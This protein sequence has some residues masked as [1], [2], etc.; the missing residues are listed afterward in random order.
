M[1]DE[2]LLEKTLAETFSISEEMSEEERQHQMDLRAAFK[3]GVQWGYDHPYFNKGCPNREWHYLTE[4]PT[5]LPEVHKV[6]LIKF[7]DGT[8]GVS[9]MVYKKKSIFNNSTSPTVVPNEGEEPTESPLPPG[10]PVYDPDSDNSEEPDT[11]E[12]PETPKEKVWVT[13][14]RD[15]I[16]A[17]SY[18]FVNKVNGNY[19]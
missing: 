15:D 4:D 11:P 3:N 14:Y 17:W 1:I 9:S 7:S 13:R 5:D 19:I 8:G 10:Y 18:Y 16:I 12:I 6:C 2:E